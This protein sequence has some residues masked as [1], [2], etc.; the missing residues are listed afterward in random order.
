MKKQLIILAI[1]LAVAAVMCLAVSLPALS[2]S[3]NTTE[4]TAASSIPSG[5]GTSSTLVL[6][7]EVR[8]YVC[9][10]EDTAAIQTVATQYTALTGVTV[11]ILTGDLATLMA[12]NAAP[13]IFCLH[14]QAEAQRWQENLYDLSG[15]DVLAQ[16]YNPDFALQLD[17]KPVA[18]A[19]NV[20]AYG[21]FYNAELLGRTGYTRADITDFASFHQKV[22]AAA[23]EGGSLGFHAFCTPDLTDPDFVA[24]LSGI[25]GGADQI[26]SLLD[27]MLATGADLASSAEAFTAGQVV[28][29]MGGSWEYEEL[30]QLDFNKLDILPFFTE[31]GSTLPCV[32]DT[33]W[34]V[35]SQCANL[36]ASLDFLT[37]L[38]TA[39]ED[40]PAPIDSLGGI[41]PFRDAASGDLFTRRLIRK[42]LA[43]EPVTVRWEVAPGLEEAALQALSR[44]LTAYAADPTDETWA[45]VAALLD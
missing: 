6:P 22:E 21:I 44:A 2:L 23:T 32:C 43:T 41:A 10:Q 7:P 33:Y 15:T 35:N 38:V 40:A 42:Y 36:R 28:F 31:N 45:A 13:T 25:P 37:W 12:S 8:L 5:T 14:S 30:S 34:A 11:R 9:G 18:L 20:S 17:G 24:M 39:T 29:H 1:C 26:R 3:H 4:D 27:L 19:M 16:L